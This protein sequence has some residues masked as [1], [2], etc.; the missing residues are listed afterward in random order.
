MIDTLVI[1][2]S[3]MMCVTVVLR[4]IWLDTRL[5]WFGPVPEPVEPPKP[6]RVDPPRDVS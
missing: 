6:L 5:P 3:T 2:F 1:L 4:A